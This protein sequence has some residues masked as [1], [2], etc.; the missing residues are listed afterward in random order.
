LGN[1]QNYNFTKRIS[2]TASNDM[3]IMND[4]LERA[5][6]EVVV[7]YANMPGGTLG[8]HENITQ[9]SQALSKHSNLDLQKER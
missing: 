9:K 2:Y 3:I 7:D 4:E 6:K 8:I 5:W 1:V